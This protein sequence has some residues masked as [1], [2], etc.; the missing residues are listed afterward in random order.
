MTLTARSGFATTVGHQRKGPGVPTS[1]RAG[2]TRPL[3]VGL[4]NLMPD[5]AVAAA[6]QQFV[7]LLVA[8]A[9]GMPIALQ[10][11]V[12]P[13]AR[14]GPVGRRFGYLDGGELDRDRPDALVVT[15][16]EPSE[17]E[18]EREP[19]WDPLVD[20]FRWAQ[21]AVPSTMLSCLASHAAL[22]ALH[23]V[24]RS[25]LAMKRSGIVDQQVDQSHPLGSG[26]GAVVALPHSRWNDVPLGALRAHGYEVVLS[27]S[28]GEWTVAQ[29]TNEGRAFVLLQGHPEYLRTTLLREYRRDV[30][31]F[32]AGTYDAYP[33]IPTCYMDV[34]GVS[35]L[36]AYRASLGRR[37]SAALEAPFPF[38]QAVRHIVASWQHVSVKLFANWMAEA[39]RRV[40]LSQ[41]R[42]AA[43]PHA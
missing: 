34:E 21:A 7:Q 6:H 9:A 39:H 4:L 1:G 22:L 5:H 38:D 36:E 8:A 30:R 27:S 40:E 20:V 14:L 42:R 11:Y 15:G 23:G 2:K 43:V 16:A 25:P 32:A 12:L 29:R 37:G 28:A 26:L 31:R 17:P 18:L 41:V 13:G 3:A 24:R 10:G 19:Y 33:D 35:M